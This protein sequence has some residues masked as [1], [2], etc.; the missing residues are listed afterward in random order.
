MVNADELRF[1]RQMGNDTKRLL[2]NVILDHEGALM[3][4]DSAHLYESTNSFDAFSRVRIKSGDTLNLYG[5]RM[6][7]NGNTR[8]AEVTGSVK[9]VDRQTTLTTPTLLYDRNTGIAYYELGGLI[10]DGSNK[11]TSRT[12]YYMTNERRIH[13]RRE[14]VL[15]NPEYVMNSDTLVYYT[16]SRVAYFHGPSTIKAQKTYIYCENGWYDTNKDKAQF[17]KK[18][19]IVSGEHILRGDSLFYDR[20]NDLGKAFEN[21]HINDTVQNILLTG[22]YGEY[23][24]T[25]G[26]TFI[27][28]RPMAVFVQDNDSLYMHADT[29]KAYFDSTQNVKH[30]KAFNLVKYFRHDLQGTCDSLV[31]NLADSIIEMHRKP[32][33]WTGENQLSAD[34]VYIKTNGKKIE[35]LALKNAAFIINREDTAS[36]NQVK[37]RNMTGFFEDNK[38]RSIIVKGNA[39]TIYFVRE[40]DNSLVGINKALS[41][42]MRI[43]LENNKIQKIF[44]FSKPVASLTPEDEMPE[45]QRYLSNFKWLATLRPLAWSDIFKRD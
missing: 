19:Y 29:I 14:V 1:A 34:T 38:L 13:F 22:N 35:W 25:L 24:K 12:G 15:E 30:I 31:Y 2:G 26:Y 7:Y 21:V 20:V 39:E 41:S 5:N 44:Y 18:A 17:N 4:C 9:L 37:G 45:T 6:I 33:I 42:S 28:S 8:I 27:T 10:I 43:E 11:L 16:I 32:V 36:F 3:Y 40:S 23:H